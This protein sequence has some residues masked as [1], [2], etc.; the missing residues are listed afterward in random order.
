MAVVSKVPETYA[1]IPYIDVAKFIDYFDLSREY[2]L[3]I[4]KFKYHFIKTFKPI[5]TK[6]YKIIKK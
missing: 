5:L 6:I 3:V 2:D 4:N 1:F